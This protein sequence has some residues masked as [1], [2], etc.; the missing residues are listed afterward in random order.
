MPLLPLFR[1]DRRMLAA[2]KNEVEPCWGRQGRS[3][4]HRNG[5]S[6]ISCGPESQ[7]EEAFT[8]PPSSPPK[9]SVVPGT[10]VSSH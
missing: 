6:N 4:M 9:L 8:N 1:R 7:S 10:A 2:T 3:E 5:F